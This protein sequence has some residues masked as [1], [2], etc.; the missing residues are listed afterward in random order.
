MNILQL[1]VS[2]LLALNFDLN[3]FDVLCFFQGRYGQKMSIQADNA[4]T[5]VTV[6]D[7]VS[8]TRSAATLLAPFL[9]KRKDDES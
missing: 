6:I 5:V 4:R 8:R 9:F 2:N 7:Q 3:K 1:N